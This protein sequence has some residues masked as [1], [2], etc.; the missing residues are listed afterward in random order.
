[1]HRPVPPSLANPLRSRPR[2]KWNTY[3][4]LFFGPP[5]SNRERPRG[6][7]LDCYVW[8]RNLRFHTIMDSRAIPPP[9]DAPES[10]LLVRPHRHRVLCFRAL[11]AP[12]ASQ[13][14]G[15]WARPKKKSPRIYIM[16]YHIYRKCKKRLEQRVARS[17]LYMDGSCPRRSKQGAGLPE[18]YALLVP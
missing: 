13:D 10:V 15:L 5:S 18:T 16:T 14:R 3:L 2:K 11:A 6:S 9:A 7:P 8:F 17:V 1:M 4:A 12:A